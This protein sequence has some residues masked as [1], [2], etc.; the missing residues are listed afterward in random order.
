[1]R[2]EKIHAAT[3]F[4]GGETSFLPFFSSNLSSLISLPHYF[5]PMQIARVIPHKIPSPRIF[6][7]RKLSRH[8]NV[9]KSHFPRKIIVNYPK[10]QK[11]SDLK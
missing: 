11:I 2:M 6:M 8:E 7:G 10:I 9:E 5:V 3:N 4:N 1:M